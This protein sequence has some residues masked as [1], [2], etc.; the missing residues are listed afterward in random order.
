MPCSIKVY[1]DVQYN[2]DKPDICSQ[3]CCSL[4]EA[5]SME[6]EAFRGGLSELF[7]RLPEALHLEE[8]GR[9]SLNR[10]IFMLA[11]LNTYNVQWAARCKET[12]G[13][14]LRKQP[15]KSVGYPVV[16]NGR[17]MLMEKIKYLFLCVFARII[18][19][20]RYMDREYQFLYEHWSVHITTW[21]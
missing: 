6:L 13:N 8:H 16:R 10:A 12:A 4:R 7:L 9:V 19:G 3:I 5:P 17:L 2:R 1:N 14:M 11:E 18:V 21:E 15:R 20:A